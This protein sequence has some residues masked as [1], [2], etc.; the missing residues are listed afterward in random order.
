MDENDAADARWT[1]RGVPKRYRELAVQAADRQDI[2]VGKWLCDAIERALATEREPMDILPPDPASDIMADRGTALAVVR[3]APPS[4]L[5]E[6]REIVAVA[7][8][9]GVL[10]GKSDIAAMAKRV[11]RDRLRRIPGAKIEKPVGQSEKPGD[12]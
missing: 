7:K 10:E 4:D 6:L 11:L 5:G 9:L 1:I 2:P 12:L 3:A 8:E